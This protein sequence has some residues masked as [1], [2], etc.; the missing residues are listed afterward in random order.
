MWL[1]G[2]AGMRMKQPIARDAIRRAL[3]ARNCSLPDCTSRERAA[4]RK[5]ASRLPCPGTAPLQLAPRPRSPLRC[6]ALLLLA[7]TTTQP[8][9][10]R[11]SLESRCLSV[12]LSLL[13]AVSPCPR[14]LCP[15]TTHRAATTDQSPGRPPR[16]RQHTTCT[17]PPTRPLRPPRATATTTPFAH[18]HRPPPC[19]PSDRFVQIRPHSLVDPTPTSV[20]FYDLLSSYARAISGT[21]VQQSSIGIPRASSRSFPHPLPPSTRPLS[22][23]CRAV[24]QLSLA[25][26]PSKRNTVLPLAGSGFATVLKDQ[27]TPLFALCCSRPAHRAFL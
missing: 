15:S 5:T 1:G 12:G 7:R 11:R 17:L 27:T 13:A 8:E 25:I 20:S 21:R 2:R 26:P 10:L 24:Q 3:H 14:P 6:A 16:H 23:H 4:L 18:H 22:G 19:L 9:G